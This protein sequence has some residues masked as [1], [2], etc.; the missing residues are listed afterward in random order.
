MRKIAHGE[1][2]TDF[3]KFLHIFRN[4]K[5]RHKLIHLLYC[6][7]QILVFS[8]NKFPLGSKIQ[9]DYGTLT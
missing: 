7:N 6:I 2:L 9:N 8:G 5:F 4:I 3:F 1:K